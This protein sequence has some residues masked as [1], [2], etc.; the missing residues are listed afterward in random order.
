MI[1]GKLKENLNE[2][3]L[4]IEMLLG[5]YYERT[6]CVYYFELLQETFSRAAKH[7]VLDSQQLHLEMQNEDFE[8]KHSIIKYQESVSNPLIE[9][10][11]NSYF[12]TVHSELEII[13]SKVKVLIKKHFN[14]SH[15]PK[16]TSEMCRIIDD[17]KVK[18]RSFIRDTIQQHQVL[19]SYNFV[20]NGI[21]HPK[22]SKEKPGFKELEKH[23][24]D[25][26]IIYLDII[27]YE[28]KDF[29]GKEKIVVIEKGFNFLITEI[30]FIILYS[31]EI[32]SFF[33]DL[34]NNSVESR[35]KAIL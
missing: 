19:L 16:K 33:Q 13:L 20:R 23:I 2:F 31:N 17:D 4:E 27:D 35:K 24:N 6:G 21:I 5:N 8:T 9:T 1:K 7:L 14:D 12:I 22:N 15:F 18:T 30:D 3:E 28:L 26:K 10:L 25:K 34:I 29:D 11:Y 32:I